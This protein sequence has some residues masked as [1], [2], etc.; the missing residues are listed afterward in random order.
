[1][2]AM[3]RKNRIYKSSTIMQDTV[4]TERGRK[5]LQSFVNTTHRFSK[6][7][8]KNIKKNSQLLAVNDPSFNF[9]SNLRAKNTMHQNYAK[10][11]KEFQYKDTHT[12]RT[13]DLGTI[14]LMRKMQFLTISKQP[15]IFHLSKRTI[16]SNDLLKRT[17]ITPVDRLKKEGNDQFYSK[18]II[19][20]PYKRLK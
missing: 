11:R 10:R 3:K 8:A 4:Y 13:K 7:L 14:M 20:F 6:H 2:K 18:S 17:L 5:V 15:Q 19:L 16:F 12:E 1:M 9:S